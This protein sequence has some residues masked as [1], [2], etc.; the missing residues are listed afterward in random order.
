MKGSFL[1]KVGAVGDL[2]NTGA[3]LAAGFFH[4]EG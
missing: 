2:A 3:R 1:A 4:K